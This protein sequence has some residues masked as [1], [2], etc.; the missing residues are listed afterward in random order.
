MSEQVHV[1]STK[2][3]LCNVNVLSIQTALQLL[4]H[5][6]LQVCGQKSM[7]RVNAINVDHCNVQCS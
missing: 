2:Y 6:Q 5:L 3:T 1:I 4:C 7:V